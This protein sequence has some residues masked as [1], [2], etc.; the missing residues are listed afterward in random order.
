MRIKN[1]FILRSI[2]DEYLLIPC[3]EA[4]LSVK[5]L[6][7]MSESGGLLCQ[8]LQNDC[9][10]D[11]LIEALLQEYDVSAEVAA[12]GVDAFLAQMRQMDMLTEA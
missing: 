6:I 8:K 4:A 2:A 7:A 11:E 1:N 9:T 12:E 10:R 5:G 3:G